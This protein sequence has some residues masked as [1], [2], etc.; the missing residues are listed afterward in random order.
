[1]VTAIN[2][3]EGDREDDYFLDDVLRVSDYGV[4]GV[5][6]KR[7]FEKI[8]I[9]GFEG[10]NV[11]LID[12]LKARTEKKIKK[13][14]IS[15]TDVGSLHHVYKDFWNDE[16][17][18]E[19]ISASL[20]HADKEPNVSC[21]FSSDDVNDITL[22]PDI[23]DEDHHPAMFARRLSNKVDF[24]R[25]EDEEWLAFAKSLNSAGQKRFLCVLMALFFR[26]LPQIENNM[27]IE[28]SISLRRRDEE[29][30]VHGEPDCCNIG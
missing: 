23:Y 19:K 27:K 18:L 7:H 11:D 13:W 30:K 12:I 2:Q 8:Y 3:F 4:T 17:I 21:Q 25:V 26:K 22:H 14:M 6:S 15:L 28:A 20:S 5:P 9:N 10:M 24:M 1:M 16:V 29:V